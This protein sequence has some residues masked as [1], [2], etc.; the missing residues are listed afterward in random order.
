MTNIQIK[1]GS[2][3]TVLLQS[4]VNFPQAF[5]E[6][7]KNSI[8]NL[9]TKVI[10]NVSSSKITIEDD[11]RGFDDTKDASGKND[12]D[13]YFVFGNSYDNSK[14]Q[15]IK[16]G[17]MGIGGKLANDKLSSDEGPDWTIETKNKN[18]KAFRLN[19]KPRNNEFLDQYSPALESLT[20]ND[21]SINS[22]SGTK[23]TIHS[24]HD[25][26]K[27]DNMLNAIKN[28]LKTFWFFSF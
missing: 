22:D 17:H 6:L 28:E 16:L 5:T 4:T 7:V 3:I 1:T 11:G 15:G 26:F 23:I 21:C 18:A 27:Q 25:F 8:Q 2:N 12:F 20:L 14:G 24:P 10:I 9:S 13:K 19:Y